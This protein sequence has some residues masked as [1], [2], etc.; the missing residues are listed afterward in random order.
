MSRQSRQSSSG[1]A[2]RNRAIGRRIRRCRVEMLLS[3]TELAGRAGISR[4]FVWALETG[5][6]GM[7]AQTLS[8]LASVLGQPME[9][10]IASGRDR[11]CGP[12]LW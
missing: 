6:L 1:R 5:R 10:L 2:A 9:Y 3:Q 11:H 4:A 12:A 8:R 7:S